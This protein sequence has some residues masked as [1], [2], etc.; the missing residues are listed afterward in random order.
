MIIKSNPTWLGRCLW[1]VAYKRRW[2]I[3]EWSGLGDISIQLQSD[4]SAA[5]TTGCR[6]LALQPQVLSVQSSQRWCWQVD[7]R[8]QHTVI[9]WLMRPKLS[10]FTFRV[11]KSSS[12]ARYRSTAG[13]HR[14]SHQREQN[15]QTVSVGTS[16]SS[17]R[18]TSSSWVSLTP[19]YTGR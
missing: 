11:L 5:L 10:S 18:A 9:E 7:R 1:T 3:R 14:L 13:Y 4:S 2:V 12:P 6:S 19:T 15:H 8:L 16:S 17:E